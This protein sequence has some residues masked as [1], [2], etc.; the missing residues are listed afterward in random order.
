MRYRFLLINCYII[1]IILVI[2]IQFLYSF[3]ELKITAYDG[4]PLDYF[5]CSVAIC[6]SYAII[7]AYG[8]D[9]NYNNRQGS[10]YIYKRTVDSWIYDTK[11]I[12][13][14][15]NEDN[16]DKRSFGDTV[17]I[18]R[19][20]A[21]VGDPGFTTTGCSYIFARNSKGWTQAVRIIPDVTNSIKKPEGFGSSIFLDD[22]FLIIGAPDS[23]VNEIYGAGAAYIYRRKETGDWVKVC[24]LTAS[25]HIRRNQE[26]GKSVSISGNFAIVGA[27][28][29]GIGSVFI[30]KTENS[31]YT[32]NR[33]Q[34]ITS[35]DN[36]EE[37]GYSVSIFE[38]YILVGDRYNSK[39]YLYKYNNS[40][41]EQVHLFKGFEN[42]QFGRYVSIYKNY[43]I[44]GAYLEVVNE[45][46]TGAAYIYELNNAN[47]I[48]K[49]VFANDLFSS[50]RN[51]GARVYISNNFAIVGASKDD[52]NGEESGAA[53]IYNYKDYLYPFTWDIDKNNKLSLADIIYAIQ[54]MSGMKLQ[55]N[56]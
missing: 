56:K 18:D 7:G 24:E 2:N 47:K 14:D 29:Q 9:D 38:N 28:G 34:V 39:A 20:Y 42:S 23:E 37:F 41:W 10:A 8:V 31:G 26:F 46:Q 36:S 27:S 16:N 3:S 35:N 32:W 12:P 45:F 30:F 51:F 1:F 33:H 6:D 52:T 15:S 48:F 17:S 55:R 50:G 5:G 22:R 19:N 21:I 44:I 54:T 43:A 11:L 40:L 25:D 53:Y 4:Y 13:N 49:K